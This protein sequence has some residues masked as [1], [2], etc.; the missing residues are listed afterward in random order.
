MQR[1]IA[2]AALVPLTACADNATRPTDSLELRL[3]AVTYP[4]AKDV[5]Y[6]FAIA[7][8]QDQLVV[9]R[10]PSHVDPDRQDGTFA[11]ALFG[12]DL[13][14]THGASYAADTAAICSSRYGNGTGGL[15]YVAPCDASSAET[16]THTVTLWLDTV[17]LGNNQTNQATAGVDYQDPCPDGCQ[18][19]ATC[20]PNADT[21]VTFNL[22]ILRSANQGFFDIAV[23]FEDIFCSAKLDTCYGTNPDT[24]A[25]RLL[26]GT[27]GDREPTAVLALACTEGGGTASNNTYLHTG[28]VVVTCGTNPTTTTTLDL[29]TITRPGNQTAINGLRWAVFHGSESLSGP[30]GPWNKEYFNVAITGFGPNCSVAWRATASHDE[31]A[32]LANVDPTSFTSYPVITF[33]PEPVTAAGWLCTQNPLNDDESSVVTVP[34]ACNSPATCIA[35]PCTTW[36]AGV[37][38]TCGEGEDPCAC[39]EPE[40]AWNDLAQ[41]PQGPMTEAA[42][43]T[44]NIDGW[45]QNISFW[46]TGND[47]L[48]RPYTPPATN[49]GQFGGLGDYEGYTFGWAGTFPYID[50]LTQNGSTEV[51]GS[52]TFDFDVPAGNRGAGWR[53]VVGLGG[54][55]GTPGEGPL[56]I[57]SSESLTRIG[58]FN[59]FGALSP[60][61]VTQSG[62]TTLLGGEGGPADGLSFFVIPPNA[63]SI[64]WSFGPTGALNGP[65]DQFGFVVG[66]VR[67]GDCPAQCLPSNDER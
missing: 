15:T 20:R 41:L 33:G 44:F 42:P 58:N 34:V 26:H 64:T 27:S 5:C 8:G 63:T 19:T 54:T 13:Y 36:Q 46:R 47:D 18:V 59:A 2:L 57:T 7:N 25:I 62:A 43:F 12:G 24:D 48:V 40:V 3:G 60:R 51:S 22:T 4:G 53:Y 9:G 23:N 17:F 39:T 45:A 32:D 67:L 10:G 50:I 66:M 30:S 1:F 31:M 14:F 11:S 38:L 61:Y 65:P 55:G 6:S 49:N 28:N 37:S 52:A 56:E 16:A 21:P 29:A 35:G